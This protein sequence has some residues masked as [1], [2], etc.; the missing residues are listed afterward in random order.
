MA[1]VVHVQPG[2]G[3]WDAHPLQPMPPL[4][5]LQC[6][7]AQNLISYHILFVQAPLPLHLVKDIEKLIESIQQHLRPVTIAHH[8]LV[9]Q[10]AR[11]HGGSLER[12]D[13]H[14]PPSQW[15]GLP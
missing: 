8:L 1:G 14:V 11:L 13:A 15:P 9:M 3:I 7:Q 5:A 4:G 2:Q 10:G 6:G 12:G